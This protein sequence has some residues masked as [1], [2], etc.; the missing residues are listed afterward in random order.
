MAQSGRRTSLMINKQ[1]IFINY[2]PGA[3]GHF[4]GSVL[5]ILLTGDRIQLKKPNMAFAEASLMNSYHNLAS[6]WD[7]GPRQ[8]LFNRITDPK[9]STR[10]VL[11]IAIKRVK[12]IVQFYDTPYDF[13]VAF[14]H[15]QNV[16]PIMLAF[17]N[18]KLFNITIRDNNVDLDQVIWNWL[19][20][21]GR[22]NF[23]QLNDHLDFVKRNYGELLDVSEINEQTSLELMFYISKLRMQVGYKKFVLAKNKNWPSTYEIPFHEIMN[24]EIKNRINS[25]ANFLKVD[26]SADTVDYI[27]NVIDNYVLAQTTVLNSNL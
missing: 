23:K 20:K 13:Y 1:Q 8:K 11:P 10:S 2:F 6:F 22:F 9:T 3:S 25:I 4:F 7:Y 26:V 24:G 16:E 17:E 14:L 15:C 18:A 5:W 21:V 27:N 12:E 19:S